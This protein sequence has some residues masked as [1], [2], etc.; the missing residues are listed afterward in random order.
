MAYTGDEASELN[1]KRLSKFDYA[2][3]L[4]ASLSY[5]FIKQQDAVGMVTFDDKV[6]TY[7]RPTAKPSQVRMILDELCKTEPGSDKTVV[8]KAEVPANAPAATRVAPASPPSTRT[9]R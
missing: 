7:L 1:G 5:L 3:H 2:R 8:P 4:A 6:R 9:W